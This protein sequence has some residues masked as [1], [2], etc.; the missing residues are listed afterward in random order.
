MDQVKPKQ[1]RKCLQ[2][3]RQAQQQRG[4]T[5][6][7][8]ALEPIQEGLELLHKAVGNATWNRRRKEKERAMLEPYRKNKDPVATAA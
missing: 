7:T 6:R 2:S 3:V 5:N 1:V 8:Q 4:W